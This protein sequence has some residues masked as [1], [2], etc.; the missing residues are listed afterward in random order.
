MIT[1][2]GF[3]VG[4]HTYCTKYSSPLCQYIYECQAYD[5]DSGEVESPTGWF[6]IAGRRTIY[7]DNCGFVN[8]VDHGSAEAA[9]EAFDAL[10][11]E[12][13]L[14]IFLDDDEV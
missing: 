3:E 4:R 10:D 8:L 13:A 1:T 6:A 9:R 5:E 11:A 7:E 14:W 2:Q 12:Y